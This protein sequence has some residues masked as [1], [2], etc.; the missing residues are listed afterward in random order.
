MKFSFQRKTKPTEEDKLR[1]L[2]RNLPRGG[3]AFYVFEGER[4]SPAYVRHPGD[5]EFEC[6]RQW[7]PEGEPIPAP[8]E[9][10][11]GYQRPVNWQAIQE[12]EGNLPG[13]FE[14]QCD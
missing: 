4:I 8:I 10:I 9:A 12:R 13:R 14:V 2:V 5:L 11:P 6:V 3:R 7:R 1:R